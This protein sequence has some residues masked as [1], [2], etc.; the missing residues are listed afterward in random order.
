MK[1]KIFIL[2]AILLINLSLYAETT[3][4]TGIDINMNDI[5]ISFSQ[6]TDK[7]E[8]KATIGYPLFSIIQG[9][10]FA[11][12]YSTQ[13]FFESISLHGVLD[14]NLINYK[15]FF[16]DFGLAGDA[17]LQFDFDGENS[18]YTCFMIGPYLELGYSFHENKTNQLDASFSVNL[19]LT[20]R[21][22]KQTVFFDGGEVD[23]WNPIIGHND[24][25]FYMAMMV[26]KL[27]FKIPLK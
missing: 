13:D 19:P 16:L 23:D 5:G 11:D 8:A 12:N 22:N 21:E 1:K 26:Y 15:S 27:N 17:F 25:I 2:L 10:E 20:I 4:Y 6:R 9:L 24:S 14:Y 7:I 3:Y 18:H